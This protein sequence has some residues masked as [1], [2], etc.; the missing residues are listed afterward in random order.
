MTLNGSRSRWSLNGIFY[1][2]YD[3]SYPGGLGGGSS[4]NKKKANGKWLIAKSPKILLSLRQEI[5]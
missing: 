2:G 4:K 1:G 3:F 5:G